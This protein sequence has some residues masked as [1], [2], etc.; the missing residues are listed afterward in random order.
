MLVAVAAA[1]A[2]AVALVAPYGCVPEGEEGEEDKEAE[3]GKTE[4]V[5]GGVE[6]AA[7]EGQGFSHGGD[8]D[9]GGVVVKEDGQGAHGHEAGGGGLQTFPY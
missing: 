8:G 5:G 3:G 6:V 1:A 7:E 2:A 4:E 9:E